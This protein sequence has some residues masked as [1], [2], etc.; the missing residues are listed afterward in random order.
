MKDENIFFGSF[1]RFRA[2]IIV[3]SEF[4]N[5]KYKLILISARTLAGKVKAAETHFV[6][7][8]QIVE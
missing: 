1:F 6:S 3:S 5:K 7:K 4:Q 8:V 2:K